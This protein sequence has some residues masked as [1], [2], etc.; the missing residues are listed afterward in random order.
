MLNDKVIG[1]SS[2]E[3]GFEIFKPLLAEMSVHR[4]HNGNFVVG[5]YIRVIRHTV[6]DNI[7]SFKKVD[8]PVVYT[9]IFNVFCYFHK[10]AS[11]QRTVKKGQKHPS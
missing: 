9:Y 11:F 6:F 7:L 10:N 4:I 5:D 2:R 1:L 8:V 3:N